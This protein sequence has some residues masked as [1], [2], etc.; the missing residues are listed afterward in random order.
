LRRT[1]L[2]ALG[3]FLVPTIAALLILGARP[4]DQRAE[5][6]DEFSNKNFPFEFSYPD[7][8]EAA[9]A[10]G[11]IPALSLDDQNAI[12]VREIDP[13]VPEGGLSAYVAQALIDQAGTSKPEEH[14]G[15]EM[16]S[17]RVPPQVTG[18][19]SLQI[20]YFSAKDKTFQIDCQFTAE[21]RR[22]MLRACRRVVNTIELE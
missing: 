3:G 13:P 1:A 2:Y 4:D 12:T 11:E 20:F 18:G 10:E 22:R 9:S 21:E 19:P 14:S 7:E 15:I 16:V 6:L 17:A 8:F 5:G